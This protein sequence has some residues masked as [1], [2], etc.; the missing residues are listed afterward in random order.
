[1]KIT[2][3]QCSPRHNGNTEALLMSLLKMLQ[4]PYQVVYMNQLNV[5]GC[6]GCLACKITGTCVIQDDMALLYDLF[7]ETNLLIMATPVYFNSVPSQAKAMVDRC[8]VYWSR[9]FALKQPK[10]RTKKSVITISTSG[11]NLESAKAGLVST[12]ELFYVSIDGKLVQHFHLSGLDALNG[13]PLNEVIAGLD[14]FNKTP[15]EEQMDIGDQ[16]LAMRQSWKESI[17][18]LLHNN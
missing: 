10:T 8:Q 14:A 1:M 3:I 7:D 16:I 18:S 5:K 17:T 6:T 11:S 12:L 9:H 4:V 2:V 15:L 13:S